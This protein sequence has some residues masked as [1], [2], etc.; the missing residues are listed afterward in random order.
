MKP[1][2]PSELKLTPDLLEYAKAVAL[3]EVQKRCPKHVVYDDV[4]QEA[5][6]QLISKPPKFDPAK[7]ASEK[8]LIY[9]IVQRAVLKSIGRSARHAKRFVQDDGVRP[10]TYPEHEGKLLEPRAGTLAARTHMLSLQDAEEAA[11]ASPRNER[12]VPSRPDEMRAAR[13]STEDILQFIDCEDSRTLCQLVLQCRGNMSE[14]ARRLGVSEGT[15]RYRLR[16]LA[17]KLAAAGFNP[18]PWRDKDDHSD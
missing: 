8:T 12:D 2:S 5:L 10:Q 3:I 13:L 1:T 18:F 6:L 14:A 7:G 9:T 4:V 17:P 16:L 11:D 15:V